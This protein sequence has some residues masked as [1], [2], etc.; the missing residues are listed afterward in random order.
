MNMNTLIISTDTAASQESRT[1]PAKLFVETTTRCNLN[2]FMCVKQNQGDG[3]AC[4][5][6]LSSELFSALEPAF[7][8]LEA[9]ILNGVGEPLLHPNLELF[10]RSAKKLMPQEGWVGFQSNGLLM[11]NLRAVSLV[12]AGLDRICLSIDSVSPEKFREVR[13]GG[14]L[15]GVERPSTL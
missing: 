5:G 9:L 12:D 15:E 2:C 14:E 13:Q 1:Y 10:I 11:T 4:D 7:P 6:D 8:H 3:A